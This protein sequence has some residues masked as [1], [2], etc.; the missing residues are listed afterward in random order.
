MVPS[1]LLLDEP[2]AGLSEA[3]SQNLARLVRGLAV[4]WGMAILV[5]E[6]DLNFVMGVCDQV[7]V[8]DFGKLISSGSPTEVQSDPEV[9]RAY[10]GA[11]SDRTRAKKNEQA[12]ALETGVSL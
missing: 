2:A 12:T 7:L 4:E 10:L 5:V 1:V 8:L 3:E 6:H 11:E 9:I